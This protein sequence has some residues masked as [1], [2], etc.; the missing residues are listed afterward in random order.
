MEKGKKEEKGKPVLLDRMALEAAKLA[1]PE[2][3]HRGIH[4]VRVSAT[5]TQVTDGHKLL[6]IPH[7]GM[8]PAEFPV[9]PGVEHK[10]DE[11]SDIPGERLTA[12]AKTLPKR[13]NI[14]ITAC[15]LVTTKDDKTQLSSNDLESPVTLTCPKPENGFP[16]THR[17]IES[18]LQGLAD[19]PRITFNL[20]NLKA[21]LDWASKVVRH[22]HWTRTTV[23]IHIKDMDSASVLKFRFPSLDDGHSR[24]AT[25]LVMPMT[26]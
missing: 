6:I 13:V 10:R 15:V 7:V 20:G 16:R 4:N 1:Q 17:I 14:P 26:D 19:Q 3:A 2:E 23:T 24:E 11:V 18:A 25:A 22:E 9:T 8:D 5:D 12:I 21:L